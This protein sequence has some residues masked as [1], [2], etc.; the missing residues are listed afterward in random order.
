M[1]K[2]GAKYSLGL[3]QGSTLN[4]EGLIDNLGE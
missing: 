4:S 3:I 1:Q 2:V